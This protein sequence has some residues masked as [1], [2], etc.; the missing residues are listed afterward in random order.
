MEEKERKVNEFVEPIGLKG[1]EKDDNPIA[2]FEP[3]TLRTAAAVGDLATCEWFISKAKYYLELYLNDEEDDV[4]EYTHRDSLDFRSDVN[5]VDKINHRT[6]M[7]YA[8]QFGHEKVVELL[9]TLP[10][11]DLEIKDKSGATPM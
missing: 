2:S 4:E 10:H 9:L 8:C 5:A 1:D 3:F 7:H 6:A 11:A